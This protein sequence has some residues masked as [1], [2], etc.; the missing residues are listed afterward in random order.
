MS[1][2]HWLWV[3]TL[4]GCSGHLS[5]DSKGPDGGGAKPA[6]CQAEPQSFMPYSS[7]GELSALL[8]GSWAN[9][10]EANVTGEDVGL[11]FTADGHWYP[12]TH[13]GTGAVV[14]RTGVDY[15]GTWQYFPVGSL[16]ATSTPLTSSQFL[17]NGVYDS[18]PNFTDA[19]RQMRVNLN[20]W[21]SI[22]V[23]LVPSP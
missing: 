12:L 17:F 8:A 19:P 13:D 22:Y 11:E 9:C 6:A 15:E 16:G 23:P 3:I 20:P 21:P 14:R 18:A 4:A 5:V 2:V 7:G 10:G 1:N